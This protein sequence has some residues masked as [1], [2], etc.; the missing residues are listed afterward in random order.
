MRLVSLYML[1]G[2]VALFWAVVHCLFASKSSTFRVFILLLT[3]VAVT[4]LGDLI[5]GE[6]FA[7][8]SVAHLLVQFLVPSLIPLTCLYFSHLWQGYKHRPVHMLWIVLPVMLFTAGLILTGALGIQGTEALIGRVIAGE[9]GAALY[10]SNMEKAYYIWTFLIFRAVMGL[11]VLF[12]IGYLIFLGVRIR[13]NPAHFRDFLVL[14]RRIRLLE[15]QILLVSFILMG[16]SIKLFLHPL[17][18]KTPLLTNA[19]IVFVSGV[20]F[21]F[22]FFGLF[23]A[24]EFISIPDIASSFRFNYNRDNAAERAA[25][26][27]LD[28]APL[29]RGEV[30]TQVLAR[31][32]VQA[33]AEYPGR[34]I[35]KAKA[36]A[37]SAAATSTSAVSGE[38]KDLLARFQQLMMDE[39]LFLQPSITLSDVAERLHTNKTY[40]SRMVN[41]NYNLGFPEVLNILRVDYAEQY[42]RKYPSANQEDIAKACGFLSAS[43]FNSTFKRITGYTPKVWAAH[44]KTNA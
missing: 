18:I 37:S 3:T 41:Q 42:I 34:N 28:M 33:G 32:E 11:E 17:L 44:L 20:E 30:L 23:G 10:L 19:L 29:L 14:R 7:L 6:M 26:I 16:L 21:L 13:L 27:I 1:P 4:V 35:G 43:S 15:I 38:E 24:R 39:Q 22:F 31:L 5:A 2:F 36:N 12:M 9:K 40:I 8:K 25:D